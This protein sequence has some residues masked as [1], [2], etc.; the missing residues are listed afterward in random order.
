MRARIGIA[1]ERSRTAIHLAAPMVAL[2][3]LGAVWLAAAI[4][5]QWNPR[6]TIDALTRVLSSIGAG[7][8]FAWPALR[9]LVAVEFL[10]GAALLLG[11]RRRA[12]LG[13]SAALLAAFTIWT[14]WSR[15]GPE[16]APCG[17][18]IRFTW[19]SAPATFAEEITRNLIL[20]AITIA[21]LAL[22]SRG[23]HAPLA[24]RTDP[25]VP[26]SFAPIVNP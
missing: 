12:A 24:A 4:G 16:G 22:E 10:L 21:M 1:L 3:M 18:A 11:R 14:L 13:G 17:C 25:V 6:P 19:S 26:D 8:D 20:L 9:V 2:P 23:A 15:G 7:P 5:K